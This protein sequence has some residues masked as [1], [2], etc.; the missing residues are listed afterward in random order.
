M[1]KTA[2]TDFSATKLSDLIKGLPFMEDILP[3]GM[4]PACTCADHYGLKPY[5]QSKKS[6]IDLYKYELAEAKNDIIMLF[7]YSDLD[8]NHIK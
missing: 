4:V 1:G 5:F 8:H 7:L 3:W 2:H 6:L